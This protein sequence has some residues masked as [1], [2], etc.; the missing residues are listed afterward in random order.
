MVSTIQADPSCFMNID[1]GT[2]ILFCLSTPFSAG[3]QKPQT[4]TALIIKYEKF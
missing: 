2:L 1:G 3:P 4:M